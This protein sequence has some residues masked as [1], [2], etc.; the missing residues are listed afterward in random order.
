M[1]WLKR[2]LFFVIGGVLALGLL[3]AA[4]FYDYKEWQ[5]N[6]T[7]FD[8][9]N[10]IYTTLQNFSRQKP[11]P[12]NSKVDNTAA[13][14]EQEKQIRAWIDKAH[15]YF[16][17]IAPIPA[18]N[19]TNGPISNETFADALHRTINQLQHEAAD[20]N[21]Q[22]PPQYDFTFAAQSD[23]VQFAPGSIEPLSVQ[24]GEVKTI[25]E[26]F[27]AARVN[28]VESIQRVRVSDD[29]TSGPPS[30]FLTD[31]SVTNDMSVITPYQVVFRGFSGEIAQVLEALASSPHCFIIKTISVLPASASAESA[32]QGMN[33][34]IP[35]M[36]QP[37][38]I[39]P[40]P[41]PMTGRNGLQSVVNEQM[42]RVTVL[43][44]VVKLTPRN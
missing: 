11:S 31:Q 22:I 39:M 20:S 10:Q 40:G 23:R 8:K 32:E 26:A 36:P 30:D 6:N 25:A 43:I 41:A 27:F 21:V 17:P 24:L 18:A 1:G 5:R 38:P 29:D 14:R 44:E 15:A 12:G 35:N 42:L 28:A 7:D 3:G 2:N 4:L 33:Q 16:Q 19:P 37:N 34:Q 9:L 13:A